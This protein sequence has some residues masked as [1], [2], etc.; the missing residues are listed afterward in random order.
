[1]ALIDLINSIPDDIRYGIFDIGLL[2]K[3]LRLWAMVH[4]YTLY[5]DWSITP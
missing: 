4:G 2:A 1:M 5:E 3:T